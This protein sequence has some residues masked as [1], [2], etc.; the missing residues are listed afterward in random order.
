MKKPI[1]FLISLFITI[2]CIAD[3]CFPQT[4]EDYPEWV[5]VGSPAC[6]CY[7]RQCYGDINGFSFL[8]KPVT[9]SDLNIF[10][11]AF[12]QAVLPEGGICADLN[13]SSFIGKRVTLSDLNI[14]K[15][16]FNKPESQVPE[17]CFEPC[18]IYPWCD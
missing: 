18:W 3:D 1:F 6:W 8:G 10:K 7:S 4:H 16:Y 14:F 12:N 15:Q 5:A 13:H 17:D 9:L 2:P 11:S